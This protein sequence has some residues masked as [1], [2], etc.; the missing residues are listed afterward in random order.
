MTVTQKWLSKFKRISWEPEILIS[1]GMLFTLL[2]APEW[3]LQVKVYLYP[4]HI[5]GTSQ[6]LAMFSIGIAA[7]TIGF[8]LHLIIKG[9]W[10]ALL[11]LQS[12]FPEG[13]N[14]EKLKYSDHFKNNIGL[15]P[16]LDAKIEKIG[17]SASL[18][19]TLSFLFLIISIGLGFYLILMGALFELIPNLKQSVSFSIVFIPWALLFIDFVTLGFLKK[20]E[21]VSKIYFPLYKILSAITLSFLYREILY[22]LISN[23]KRSRIYLFAILFMPL[24]LILGWRN[25]SQALQRPSPLG[26]HRFEFY[27]TKSSDYFRNNLYEDLRSPNDP[28]PTGTIQ[29]YYV[30]ENVIR[31]YVRYYNWMES[32]LQELYSNNKDKTKKEIIANYFLV[33]IDSTTID[34]MIWYFNTHPKLNQI[35]LMGIIPLDDLKRGEHI[36]KISTNEQDEWFS[37]PFWKD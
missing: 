32:E 10:I 34:D 20:N 22:S 3:L 29:S 16:T 13:I 21:Y 11:A 14:I 23:I 7:L 27:E 33:K 36:V 30:K 35:G 6:V 17:K 8:I 18:M 26:T 25:I 5:S 1:G 31:L 28:I 19:F 24:T 4:F 37:I 2:Q 12:V 15:H 9:F